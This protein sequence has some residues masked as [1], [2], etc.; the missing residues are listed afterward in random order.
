MP[1]RQVRL[2][3]DVEADVEQLAAEAG[4]LSKATNMLVREALDART[5]K[6]ARATS[7]P[8][9]K[10]ARVSHAARSTCPHPINRRIGDR[11]GWCGAT[12]R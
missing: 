11:C 5:G 2:D 4:S 10:R 8:G 9:T 12:V 6:P 1:G 3:P 7:T